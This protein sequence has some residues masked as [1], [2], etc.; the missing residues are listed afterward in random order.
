MGQ[1]GLLKAPITM[2]SGEKREAV[3]GTYL[4]VDER[5]IGVLVLV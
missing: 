3:L 1:A 5:L 4:F 2:A